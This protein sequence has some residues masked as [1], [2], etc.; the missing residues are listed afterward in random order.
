MRKKRVELDVDSIGNQKETLTKKE[1]E[2][3]SAYISSHK[4]K[5]TKKSSRKVNA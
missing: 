2:M 1:E 4:I 3:I 5:R